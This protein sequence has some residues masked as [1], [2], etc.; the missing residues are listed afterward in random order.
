VTRLRVGQR[1]CEITSTFS[2]QP[3]QRFRNRKPGIKLPYE[4]A[5]GLSSQAK[6]ASI[7]L[8]GDKGIVAIH[9]PIAGKGLGTGVVVSPKSVVRTLRLPAT[10]KEGNMEQAMLI[11]RQDDQG[12]VSYRAGFAWAGDG[13][14]SS[15]AGWL[16][17]LKLH[18]TP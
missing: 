1:L 14:I 3:N 16:D 2:N 4:V 18:S 5:V 10:D 15:E 12:R 8:L 13:E 6:G 11:L 7:T 17:Y 9:E